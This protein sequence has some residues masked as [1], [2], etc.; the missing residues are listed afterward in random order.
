MIF[1]FAQHTLNR[2]FASM[3]E[4]NSSRS[5]PKFMSQHA[6]LGKT[7]LDLGEILHLLLCFPKQDV[8]SRNG[9]SPSETFVTEND[10][11]FLG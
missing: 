2:D 7:D 3:C 1:T 9:F 5:I 8:W 11:G 6:K 4:F 10:V